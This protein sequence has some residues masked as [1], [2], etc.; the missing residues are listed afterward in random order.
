MGERQKPESRDLDGRSVACR[1]TAS[2]D[3]G[4]LVPSHPLEEGDDV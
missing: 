4:R 2:L 1:L 3:L